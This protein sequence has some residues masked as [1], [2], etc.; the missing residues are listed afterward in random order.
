MKYEF[1][2]LPFPFDDL[3]ANKVRPAICLTDEIPPYRHVVVA[4]IT[5]QVPSKPSDTDLILD[6]NSPDFS[7]TGLKVS[8]AIRFHRLL[9][10]SKSVIQR[11]LGKLPKNQT[12]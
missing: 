6:A 3:S 2:L 8:S 7:Q 10:I 12:N 5:S 4:F 9:T 1:V 11:K